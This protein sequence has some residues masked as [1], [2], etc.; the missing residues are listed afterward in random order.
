M[1]K[2]S[3]SSRST[4]LNDNS[5]IGVIWG[6]YINIYIKYINKVLIFINVKVN[7]CDRFCIS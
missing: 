7:Y 2:G 5:K 3:I 4:A 1:R 6:F